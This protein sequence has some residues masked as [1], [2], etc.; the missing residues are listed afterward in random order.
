MLYLVLYLTAGFPPLSL[1]IT[2]RL[3]PSSNLVVTTLKIIRIILHPLFLAGSFALE[4]AGRFST[5]ALPRS[6][7]SVRLEKLS[8]KLTP[9]MYTL[10]CYVHPENS[11]RF[12]TQVEL[13]KIRKI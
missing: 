6:Y 10:L 4:F 12:K 9:L 3:S 13:N 1:I 8:A 5:T 2:V 11:G 7:T